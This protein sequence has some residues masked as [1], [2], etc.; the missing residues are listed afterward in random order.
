MNQP[1]DQAEPGFHPDSARDQDRSVTAQQARDDTGQRPESVSTAARA[2][3]TDGPKRDLR[4]RTVQRP[5]EE[6]RDQE[7]QVEQ[8]EPQIEPQADQ[9]D[10]AEDQVELRRDQQLVQERSAAAE[11]EAETLTKQ[12]ADDRTEEQLS[13]RAM[14]NPSTSVREDEAGLAQGTDERVEANGRDAQAGRVA[15]IATATRSVDSMNA[16]APSRN[17]D[18][19]RE[20]A[21]RVGPPAQTRKLALSK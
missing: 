13:D 1:E 14:D 2:L 3:D 15:S 5:D 17:P 9:V 20:R 8:T 19:A 18:K 11:H 21:Q 12:A 10:P 6:R 16:V 4:L 7:R